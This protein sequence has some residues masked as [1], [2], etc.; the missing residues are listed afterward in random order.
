MTSDRLLQVFYHLAGIVWFVVA[1]VWL[2][3]NW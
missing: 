1:T 3:V 2:V